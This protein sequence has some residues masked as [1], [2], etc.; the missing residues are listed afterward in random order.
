MT[1]ALW[2]T[3]DD[4]TASVA[5]DDAVPVVRRALEHEHAGKARTLAKT[6]V[7]WGG[8]NTLH[9]LG[10]VAEGL[11]LVGAKTWAHTSGGANPL[12][13]LWNESNGELVAVIEAFA[14]GQLRTASISAVAIGEL[15][16]PD[17]SV[18]AVI[19]TGQQ[20]LAQVAAAFC[21]R[22]IATVR[23]FSPTREHRIAF[24]TMLGGLVPGCAIEAC[25]SVAA[26]VAGAGI[27][28]TVT[29]SREAFLDPAML[30]SDVLVNAVGAISPERAEVTDR[31]VAGASMVVSDSPAVAR[32]L[33]VELR[34]ATAVVSLSAVVGGGVAIPASGHRMFKAM[35]LGLADVAVAAEVLRRCTAD[36]RG[37]PLPGRARATPRLF[38]VKGMS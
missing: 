37:R 26:A 4:V 13:V 7:G 28:T 5:L 20:A 24:A 1:E 15:A 16:A 14:L 22:P 8:G 34:H 27:V 31:F 30:A 36:G 29:R 9:A 33:S 25:D 17:S 35:G 6:A 11:G 3:E 23:V 2:L 19:G 12:V 38:P 18:L 21:Q 10:G 32:E